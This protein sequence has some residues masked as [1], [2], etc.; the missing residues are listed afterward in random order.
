MTK[1]LD[2]KKDRT[3]AFWSTEEIESN[4]EQALAFEDRDLVDP[5]WNSIL[6]ELLTY[7][8]YKDDW[9]GMDAAS[10]TPEV[11]SAAIQIALTL[12]DALHP[13]PDA[14]DMGCNGTI[15]FETASSAN[16]PF[17]V[18]TLEVLSPTQ[19]ELYSGGR[20]I[21]KLMIAN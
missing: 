7:F 6:Q 2:A 17:P 21:Q 18:T 15:I 5:R 9:D 14:V 4:A 10:A 11:V 20:L 16:N 8:D 13:A 1:T 19:A 12:R 3:T